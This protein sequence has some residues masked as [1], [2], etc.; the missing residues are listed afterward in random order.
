MPSCNRK[1]CFSISAARG[2]TI[3]GS[4]P[5]VRQSQSCAPPPFDYHVRNVSRLVPGGIGPAQVDRAQIGLK[6]WAISAGGHAQAGLKDDVRLDRP[7]LAT[8]APAR[9]ISGLRP[10]G[11]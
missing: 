8:P 4:V 1:L 5:G 3:P 10:M 7:T 2:P 9:Q 11:A 6:D